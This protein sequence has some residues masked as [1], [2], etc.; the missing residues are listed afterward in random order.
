LPDDH[1]SQ[2]QERIEKRERR[3]INGKLQKILIAQAIIGEKK[4]KKV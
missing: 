3:N 4:G 1:L 2:K